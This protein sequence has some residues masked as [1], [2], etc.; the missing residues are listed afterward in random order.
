MK[1]N[2]RAETAN[3]SG[4]V[5]ELFAENEERQEKQKNILLKILN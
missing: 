2:E 1:I 3:F 4:D 5:L